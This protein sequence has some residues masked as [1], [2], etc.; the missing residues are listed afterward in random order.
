MQ[1]E[2]MVPRRLLEYLALLPRLVPPVHSEPRERQA[3]KEHQVRRERK[4]RAS[5]S[6]LLPSQSIRWQLGIQL[7]LVAQKRLAR[8]G[9]QGHLVQQ[10]RPVQREPQLEALPVAWEH[11]ALPVPRFGVCLEHPERLAHLVQM[12]RPVQREPQLEVQPVA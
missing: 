3:P 11:P 7:P 9:Q 10:E 1:T 4:M 5:A 8:R 2:L 12:E 6:H